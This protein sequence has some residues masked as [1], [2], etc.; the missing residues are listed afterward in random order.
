MIFISS[1]LLNSPFNFIAVPIKTGNQTTT[2]EIRTFFSEVPEYN[3]DVLY[4]LEYE[5]F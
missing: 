1:Y 2:L 5:R 3:I 4:H